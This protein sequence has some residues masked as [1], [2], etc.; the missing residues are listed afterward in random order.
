MN[1][2]DVASRSH[3]SPDLSAGL[4][5]VSYAE[6]AMASL[7]QLHS[8][9]LEEKERRV[10]LHRRLMEKEQALA[11]LKMYVRMLEEKLQRP[12]APAAAPV[13]MPA[14]VPVQAA[15]VAQVPRPPPMDRQAPAT[16]RMAPVAVAVGVGARARPATDGW[17]AW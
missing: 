12:A 6:K 4:V 5:P 14:P 2:L 10:D 7:L 16:R 3:F 9:V 11:E 8:E 17:K 15:P 13:P 1:D